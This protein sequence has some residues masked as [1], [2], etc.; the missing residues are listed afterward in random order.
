MIMYHR[1]SGMLLL[2]MAVALP[3]PVTAAT[4]STNLTGTVYVFDSAAHTVTLKDSGGALTTLTVNSKSKITRNG[5]KVTLGGLVLGDQGSAVADTSNVL[6]QLTVKGPVVTAVQGRMEDLT[7]GTGTVHVRSGKK[8]KSTETSGHTRVM[9]NGH[10]SSLNALTSFDNI[11]A[12]MSK[13]SHHA[14]DIQAEGPEDM[15]IKGTVTAVTAATDAL[16]A[17]V[18]LLPS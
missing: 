12:H 6:I 18:T 9:R 5:K 4:S 3:L 15:E 1:L 8:L 14:L 10:V 16:P 2:V 13:N 7:S 17:S 11:I